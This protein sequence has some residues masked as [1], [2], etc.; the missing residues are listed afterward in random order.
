MYLQYREPNLDKQVKRHPTIGM[1]IFGNLDRYILLDKD[2]YNMELSMDLL[3]TNHHFD[4]ELE[5]HLNKGNIHILTR[6]SLLKLARAKI[7]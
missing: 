2:I 7:S 4:I 5:Y 6:Q 3:C 1:V